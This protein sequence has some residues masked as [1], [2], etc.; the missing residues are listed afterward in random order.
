MSC[1]RFRVFSISYSLAKLP[2]DSGGVY[3]GPQ[4]SCL[5]SEWYAGLFGSP[6]CHSKVGV[7]FEISNVI[8]HTVLTENIEEAA[9]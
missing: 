1:I 9:G 7:T 8:S 4:C 6:S 2:S 5:E 3:A